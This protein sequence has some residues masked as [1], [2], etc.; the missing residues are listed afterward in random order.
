MK[1]IDWQA[2]DTS[3]IEE[4][5]AE[6]QQYYWV[7]Y[8][9][10]LAKASLEMAGEKGDAVMREGIRAYGRERGQRMRRIAN[11]K[12]YPADLC[13]LF[14]H[15]DLMSDPRFVHPPEN[16][17]L[18]PEVKRSITGRCPDAEM[19]GLMP[20]GMHIGSIYCEEVHHQIYE[21]FDPAI[22]VN[23]AETLTTGCP[24]CRFVL[25]C[26]KANQKEYPLPEYVPQIWDDFEDDMVA[27]IHSMSCL[28]YLKMSKAVAEGVG[29]KVVREAI[30]QFCYFRGYRMRLLHERKGLPIS[31]KSFL[32]EGDLFL[33]HRFGLKITDREDGSYEVTTDRNIL[34]E[35]AKTY[36]CEELQKLY[37]EISY[38]WLLKGYGDDFSVCSIAE[39]NPEKIHLIFSLKQG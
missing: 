9:Y 2:F 14:E 4:E 34:A 21:G 25:Y 31:I 37:D 3:V 35:V 32:E 24:H 7:G 22:Q 33:D 26:R 19:W 10:F 5:P 12:G 38:E 6:K 28:L 30:E 1:E 16:Y 23:L 29:L 39:D 8:Y 20:D 13:T 27:S 36:E 18:T 15:Y 11:A 17:L